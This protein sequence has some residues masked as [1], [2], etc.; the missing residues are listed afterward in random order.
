MPSTPSLRSFPNVAFETVPKFVLLTMA[1]S[2]P[3]REDRLAL[4][5][6]ARLSPPGDRWC[7]VLGFV[8]A[9]SVSSFSTLQIFRE[10]SH[11]YG[12]FSG[13]SVCSVISLHSGKMATNQHAESIST[14]KASRITTPES[15]TVALANMRVNTG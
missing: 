8:P 11:L 5:L 15:P 4:I 1:L 7:D 9:G 12:C 10:A 2:R 14:R 13:Q 6:F 3:F